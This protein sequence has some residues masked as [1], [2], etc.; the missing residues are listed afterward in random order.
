MATIP[1]KVR[2]T[3]TDQLENHARTAWDERCE[4]VNVRF[5]GEHAYIEAI[6]SDPWIHPD[7]T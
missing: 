3:L 1:E 5:R 2:T 6:E 4:R 7:A